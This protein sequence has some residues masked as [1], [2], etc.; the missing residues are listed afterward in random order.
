MS[1][2]S[3]SSGVLLSYYGGYLHP[4]ILS[5]GTTNSSPD[6]PLYLYMP[7]FGGLNI[8]FLPQFT[9]L[10]F[11]ALASSAVDPNKYFIN[12][13]NGLAISVAGTANRSNV[14]QRTHVV[15]PLPGQPDNPEAANQHWTV[16]VVRPFTLPIFG[17]VIPGANLCIIQHSSGG[18]MASGTR[19]A[20]G[21]NTP[22]VL[23]SGLSG[24][25]WPDELLWIQAPGTAI[26]T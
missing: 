3:E 19:G 13:V 8:S 23:S 22:V 21:F 1:Q 12:S 26:F 4:Q 14:I 24:S 2:G 9:W 6:A 10:R 20:F 15:Q 16:S 18:Y 7:G 5:D 17:N 25:D 11:R